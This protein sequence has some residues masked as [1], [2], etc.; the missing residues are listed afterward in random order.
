LINRSNSLVVDDDWQGASR[1]TN[2]ASLISSFTI[3]SGLPFLQGQS[4]RIA[5]QSDQVLFC[6]ESRIAAV[7]TNGIRSDVGIS[8]KQTIGC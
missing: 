4:H 5:R 3:P 2:A 6:E 8:S 1:Q 7:S